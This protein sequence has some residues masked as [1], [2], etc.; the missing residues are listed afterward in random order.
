[1]W[2]STLPICVPF[3]VAPAH[4]SGVSDQAP[5]AH[6]FGQRGEHAFLLPLLAKLARLERAVVQ[7]ALPDTFCQGVGQISDSS[8]MG[9][10]LQ[11]YRSRR[12]VMQGWSAVTIW[13]LNSRSLNALIVANPL[14]LYPRIKVSIWL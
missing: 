11:P 2:I 13:S 5:D 4:F 10:V 9:S 6:S 7:V 12:L 8:L 1:M 14:A 3:G